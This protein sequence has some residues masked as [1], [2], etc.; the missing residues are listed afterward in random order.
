MKDIVIIGAG[1][2]GKE[3]A[4]LIKQINENKLTWN[5]LGFVDDNV[6]L[7]N[8]YINGIKVICNV[9]ELC[10][11]DKDMFVVCA[12]ANY[13]IKKSIVSKLKKNRHIKFANIIHPEVYLCDSV[14][15]G[16]DVIIYP[17][18]IL[19]TNITIGDHV[20]ISPRCGIGHESQISDYS[21]L[22]WNVSISG[23][24]K[25]NEGCLLG[26]SSTVIQNKS[27]GCGSIIGAG[28]VVVDDIPSFCTAVGVPAKPIKFFKKEG[29]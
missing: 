6:E 14:Q 3:T 29:N 21:S 11:I 17:G 23:N 4:L 22:L 25:I 2:V 26:S 10:D 19:T 12:I 18:C 27:I 24:V 8:K 16:E 13:K 20:I 7:Q 9:E 15:L 1:G 28:A 5:L